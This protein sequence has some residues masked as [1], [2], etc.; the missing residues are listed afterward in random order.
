MKQLLHYYQF[1][2]FA[3][4]Y[5]L[6]GCTK[7]VSSNAT[8]VHAHVPTT[9]DTINYRPDTGLKANYCFKPGTYWIHKDAIT[10]R[11]DSFYV[12]NC[13]HDSSSY[14]RIDISN[15]SSNIPDS[16]VHLYIDDY[17]T[18]Y[19]AEANIDGFNPQDSSSWIF[20]LTN[21]PDLSYYS[22]SSGRKEVFSFQDIF[23]YPFSIYSTM[24]STLTL[25]EIVNHYDNW[26]INGN[27]FN[28]VFELQRTLSHIQDTG[29]AFFICDK[30]GMLK[31]RINIGS[32]HVWELL[33]YHIVL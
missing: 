30:K 6:C 2:L 32:P 28:N 9:Y 15:T 22:D 20:Y 5:I 3:G 1:I 25:S 8:Q 4:F 18:I 29:F 26:S 13:L 33:R 17:Y 10:G 11:I 21:S 7:N 16:A 24:G 23:F 12:T 14:T 31:M 19:I 27:D